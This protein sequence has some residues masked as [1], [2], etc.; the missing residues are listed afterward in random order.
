MMNNIELQAVKHAQLELTVK[1]AMNAWYQSK[2]HIGLGNPDHL[3]T[4][5]K[6][7]EDIRILLKIT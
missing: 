3:E 2:N 4:A 6:A 5:I 1:E 7:L